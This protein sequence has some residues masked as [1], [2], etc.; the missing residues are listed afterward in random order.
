MSI[1]YHFI[2]GWSISTAAQLMFGDLYFHNPFW[3]AFHNLLHAPIV[4][5]VGITLV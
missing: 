5:L 1:Y 4:L 2:L 3:I